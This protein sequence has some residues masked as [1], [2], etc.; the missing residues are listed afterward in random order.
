MFGCQS[1]TGRGV[2]RASR[3]SWPVKRDHDA[4]RPIDLLAQERPHLG[5]LNPHPYDLAHTSTSVAS[6]QFRITLDTNQGREKVLGKAAQVRLAG[7]RRGIPGRC[8]RSSRT[9]LRS[10]PLR[11][12]G[13]RRAEDPREQRSRACGSAQSLIQPCFSHP[14]MAPPSSRTDLAHPSIVRKAVRFSFIISIEIPHRNA[15]RLLHAVPRSRLVTHGRD[16]KSRE[17]RLFHPVPRPLC[18]TTLG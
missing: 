9:R 17:L 15:V 8:R 6:S 2:I 16:S 4:S 11:P 1:P 3:A 10:R 5:P 7:I 14:R 18:T 12:P 13:R